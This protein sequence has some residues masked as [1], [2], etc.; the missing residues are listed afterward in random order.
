MSHIDVAIMEAALIGDP[1]SEIIAVEAQLRSAQLAG[2]TEALDQLIDSDLLFSGPDG[3]LATKAQD[4]DAHASGA[5]RFQ[6]HQPEELRI[7]RVGSNVAVTSLR[8]RLAV[9]FAGEVVAGV[10]R[11]TRVWSRED[12]RWQVVG[13]HVSEVA[14]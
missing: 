7:R 12:G 13:G 10:Y 8:A 3:K 4:L 1:D 2:D 5:V 14:T 9:A 6:Q 11:Y